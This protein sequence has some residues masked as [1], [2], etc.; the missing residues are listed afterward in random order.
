[1]I[2]LSFDLPYRAAL[3]RA[4]FLVSDCNVDALRWIDN[5]PDWPDGVLVLH[6]PAG[7]GKTH[8]AHLWRERSAATI[9]EGATLSGAEPG[10]FREIPASPLAVDDAERV[11]EEV[12]FHLY[13]GCR[14]RR[15]RLLIITRAAPGVWPIGLPDLASRLRGALSV[16]IDNPDDALLGAVLVKHFTDRQ[17]PVSPEVIRYVLRRMERSFAAAAALVAGLDRLQLSRGGPVTI[18]LARDLLDQVPDQSL[19]PSDFGVA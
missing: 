13:N 8:L 7:C 16:G 19:L 14:E 10:N 9:I 17:L 3:G 1:M 11:P 12:L 2:Q 6:G 4:D 18:P 5:W 15:G